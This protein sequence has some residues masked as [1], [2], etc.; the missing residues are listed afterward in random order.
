MQA[1]LPRFLCRGWRG[2]RTSCCLIDCIFEGVE[3]NPIT[4]GEHIVPPPLRFF[5][6]NPN[7]RVL[8]VAKILHISK[9]E[10]CE[11]FLDQ[12]PT[13]NILELLLELLLRFLVP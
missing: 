2:R 3:V 6:F 12:K 13:E 7:R 11:K 8:G 4:K 5:A 9:E 10:A 1:G